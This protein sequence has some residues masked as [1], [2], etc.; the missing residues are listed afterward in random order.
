[1]DPD[2]AIFVSDLQKVF[3][4]LPFVGI[5]ISFFKDQVIKKSQN[6]RNQCLQFLLDDKHDNR[7]RMQIWEAQKHMD[8]MD[9]DSDPQNWF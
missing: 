8:P 6:S 9:P 2:H 3:C 5:F 7:I 4:L 1:M